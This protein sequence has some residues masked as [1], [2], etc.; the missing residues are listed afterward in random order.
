MQGSKLHLQHFFLLPELFQ[1]FKKQRGS[2]NQN[3]V[4]CGAGGVF[5]FSYSVVRLMQSEFQNLQINIKQPVCKI[6]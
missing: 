3:P 6:C 1:S 2:D 4:A 5:I